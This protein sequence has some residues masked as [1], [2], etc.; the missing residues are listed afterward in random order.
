VR[1]LALLLLAVLVLAPGA[2]A[3][4][5][6]TNVSGTA[7]R[8]VA[9]ETALLREINDVRRGHGLRPL[10]VSSKLSLAAGRR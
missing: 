10:V 8:E 5:A 2:L 6:P 7:V 1:R 9:L 3:S 4:R